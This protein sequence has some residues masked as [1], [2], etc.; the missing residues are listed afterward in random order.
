MT[1]RLPDEVHGLGTRQRPGDQGPPGGAEGVPGRSGCPPE[2]RQIR[3]P[4]STPTTKLTNATPGD[5]TEKPLA[6][7]RPSPMNTMLPVIAA[8]KT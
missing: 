1:A 7:A 8:T 4:A 6:P 3:A 2:L 5:A